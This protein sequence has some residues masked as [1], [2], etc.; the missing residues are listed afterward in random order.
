MTLME[1]TDT[2]E[3]ALAAGTVVQYRKVGTFRVL[4][5]ATPSYMSEAGDGWYELEPIKAPKKYREDGVRTY[6][7]GPSDVVA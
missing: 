5:P 7:V 6:W 4:R 2:T 3:N 1:I